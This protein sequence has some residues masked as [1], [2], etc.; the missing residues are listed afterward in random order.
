MTWLTEQA[1][2]ETALLR[3]VGLRP[4]L[5]PL[6]D[7]FFAATWAA[8]TDALMLELCRLRI[9]QIHGDRGQLAL[10]HEPALAAGL[11]EEHVAALDNYLTSPLFTDQQRR[12]LAYAEQYVIDVHGISDADAAAV[13]QDIPADQFVAF[14]VALGL[15]DGLGR[16]RLALGIVEDGDGSVPVSPAH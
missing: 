7:E 8:T 4:E 3:T 16:M 5:A 12:C 15:F 1:G 10:R 14:T 6:L 9:A 2:G 13:Q 11:T